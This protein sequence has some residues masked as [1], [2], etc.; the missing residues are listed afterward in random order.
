MTEYFANLIERS[1]L[2]EHVR[3]QTVTQEMRTFPG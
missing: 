2:A 1:A 3:R